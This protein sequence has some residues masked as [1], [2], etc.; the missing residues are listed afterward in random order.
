LEQHLSLEETG[1]IL[2]LS[3]GATSRIRNQFLAQEEGKPKKASWYEKALPERR[4]KEAAILNEVLAKA[5]KGGVMVVPPLKSKVEEKLGKTICLATLYNLLHRHGFRKLAPDTRHPKGDEKAREDWKKLPAQLEEIAL[6]FPEK[7]PLRVLFQDEARFGRISRGRRCGCKKPLRPLVKARLTHP[8]PYAYDAVSP[9][10]GRLDSL[11]LPH[12]NT[13][14]MPI[15]LDEVAER[16]PN[17]NLI[18][19]MDGA[20]WHQ[21]LPLS[22][23]DNLRRPF[24]PPYRPELNPQEHLWDELREKHFHNIAFNSLSALEDTLVSPDYSPSKTI[25]NSSIQYPHGF[26]LLML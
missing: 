25:P 6:S 2:G 20:G 23:P 5:A 4:E 15:F 22:L 21:S 3:R 24:L 17:E 19:I 26:G 18:M 12:V 14:C 13:E 9:L 16:H 7:R 10:D 1:E 11:I 8:Y